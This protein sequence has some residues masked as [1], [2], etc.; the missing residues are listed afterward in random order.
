MTYAVIYFCDLTFINF[1]FHNGSKKWNKNDN[2]SQTQQRKKEPYI[3]HWQNEPL[4]KSNINCE[5]YTR[6]INWYDKAEIFFWKI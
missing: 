4:V 6:N 3:K 2:L 1:K 5:K